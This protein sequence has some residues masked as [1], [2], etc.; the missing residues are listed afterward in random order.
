MGRYLN[1]QF[2][3]IDDNIDNQLI[4]KFLTA[5]RSENKYFYFN[6]GKILSS[7]V[8]LAKTEANNI[9]GLTG[10]CRVYGVPTFFIVV[11]K[12]YQGKGYARDMI[13]ALLPI[14]KTKGY[15]FVVLTVHRLNRKALKLYNDRGFYSVG[16]AGDFLYMIIALTYFGRI[17]GYLMKR[18][19]PFICLIERSGMLKWRK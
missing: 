11:K 15:L 2:E 7:D 17:V 6:I 14:L 3:S 19:L 1:R 5:L 10:I 4:V 8:L 13:E 16:I 18:C 12:E 9:A